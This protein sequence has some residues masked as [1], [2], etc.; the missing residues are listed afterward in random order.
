MRQFLILTVLTA[1]LFT[2]CGSV[3]ERVD[4]VDLDLD[5][6]SLLDQVRDCDALSARLVDIVRSA[7]RAV[8]D[9]AASTDGRVRETTI[10]ETVDKLAVSKFFDLAERIGCTNLEFKLNAI[11]Q[12]REVATETN[13]GERL[14]EEIL[15][16]M[17]AQP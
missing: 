6:D 2:S 1:V 4:A 5:L 13:A 7:A 11:E 10:R 3:Q 12:L 9:L 8:D 14:L 16:Q 15:N 17:D